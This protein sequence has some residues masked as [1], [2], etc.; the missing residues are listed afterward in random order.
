MV[1]H[2]CQMFEKIVVP[3]KYGNIT[4][5]AFAKNYL[6]WNNLCWLALFHMTSSS[7]LTSPVC[8]KPSWL[9]IIYNKIPKYG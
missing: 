1:M 6:N 3:Y 9:T 7:S 5:R 2:K 4:R 8:L